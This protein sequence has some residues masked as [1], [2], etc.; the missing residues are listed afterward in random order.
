M[1]PSKV[2]TKAFTY[3]VFVAYIDE[4]KEIY[5]K[6]KHNT[7]PLTINFPSNA[8]KESILGYLRVAW[9]QKFGSEFLKHPFEQTKTIRQVRKLVIIKGVNYGT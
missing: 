3:N 7:K 1:K 4:N 6:M 9:T 8:S 2:G 5:G